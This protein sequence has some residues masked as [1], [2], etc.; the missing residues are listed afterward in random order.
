M[1]IPKLTQSTYKYFVVTN[2]SDSDSVF[3]SMKQNKDS[4]P[5]R[6]VTVNYWW[7]TLQAAANAFSECIEIIM[8]ILFSV[9]SWFIH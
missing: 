4:I 9:N 7:I 6:I 8:N 2:K 3:I 1:Q 5:V